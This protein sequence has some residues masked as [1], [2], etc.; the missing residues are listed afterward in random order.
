MN[1]STPD[2]LE[3]ATLTV[4]HRRRG[5][6]RYRDAESTIAA[7]AAAGFAASNQEAA[8]DAMERIITEAELD[9]EH[10]CWDGTPLP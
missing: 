6:A 2:Y 7:M 1:Y 3:I 5:L 9:A 4:G 8:I 10:F